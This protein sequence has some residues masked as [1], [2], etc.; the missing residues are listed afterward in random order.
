MANTNPT[1]EAIRLKKH[2]VGV[3]ISDKM[4]KTVVVRADRRMVHPMYE[5][6]VTI[7]KKFVAHDEKNESKVGDHVKIR[8]TRPLSKTKRWV[9]VETIRKAAQEAKPAKASAE[10][11]AATAK[12]K[13]KTKAAAKRKKK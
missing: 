2:L 3:V 12:A 8:Q 7:S 10:K 1:T 6:V 4:D 11:V 5:K 13:A 9:V